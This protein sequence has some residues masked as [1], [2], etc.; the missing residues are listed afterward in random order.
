MGGNNDSP[1]KLFFLTIPKY[2]IAEPFSVSLISGIDNFSLERDR[3]Q[4]SVGI[5]LSHCTD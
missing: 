2:F 3:S 4:F 5:D 1:S